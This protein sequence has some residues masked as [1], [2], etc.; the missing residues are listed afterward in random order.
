MIY[1]DFQW[2][3]LEKVK[4]LKAEEKAKIENKFQYKK[5]KC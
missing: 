4:E 2:E 3:R 5:M 1:N